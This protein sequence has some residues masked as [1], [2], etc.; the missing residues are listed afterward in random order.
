M[1]LLGYMACNDELVIVMNFINGKTLH[2]MIFD[3]S[4]A[5]ALRCVN[6]LA[7]TRYYSIDSCTCT[8]SADDK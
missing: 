3:H 6:C 1:R 4:L 5:C 8:N 2:H 7:V